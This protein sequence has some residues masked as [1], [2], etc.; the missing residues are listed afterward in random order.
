MYIRLTSWL[1]TVLIVWAPGK[2]AAQAPVAVSVATD[3]TPA[4][5]NSFLPAMSATGRF[6]A[7]TSFA[8]NLVPGDTNGV[9]D[10]FLR[11]RDTDVDGVFDEAGAV[12]T[13]RVSQRGGVE[14]IGGSNEAAI[15]A[16]GHYVVFSSFA[17]NLF[18]AAQA[19]LPTTAIL[20][21]DRLT[22][23]IVL[24]SQTTNGQLLQG[25]RSVA[26]DLADDGDTVVFLH[27]GSLDAEKEQGHRGIIYRRDI[28]AGTLTEVSTLPLVDGADRIAF[29]ES[30]TISGDGRT[31]A[32]AAV[33]KARFVTASGPLY[34]TTGGNVHLLDT[35]TNGIRSSYAG[36]S[37]KLS[38]NGAF[39]AFIGDVGLSPLGI[40]VR[41]HLASG[42]RLSTGSIGLTWTPASVSPS[43]RFFAVGGEVADYHYGSYVF[44]PVGDRAAF[45]STDTTAAVTRPHLSGLDSTPV[46]VVNLT[47]F[48]DADGDGLNDHWEAVFG[49]GT[50]PDGGASGVNGAA[51]DPDNDGVS[52]ADELA[53]GSNPVGSQAL[54]LAEGAAGTFFTTRYA[55]ANPGTTQANVSLRLDL[56]GGGHVLRTMWVPGGS[57]VS[58][59]SRSLGLGTASFSAAVESSQPVVADRLMSWGDGAVPYGSHA[60]TASTAPGTSW[61]LAEGSTVLGFQLF[62]LLQ[63]PQATATTA[64]VRFLLPS[65]APIVRTYAL[66]ARSRTTIL[67]TTCPGWHRPTSPPRS[68][69]PSASPSSGR[70]IA[71]A[72]DRSSLWDT[73]RV[74]WPSHRRRGSLPK[75]PPGRSSTPICCWP[76]HRR[77]RLR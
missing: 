28:A 24:V 23:D 16:D 47:T 56:D 31:I 19:P 42:E 65:G 9:E 8:T 75:A 20:R 55:I 45:D 54:F 70:C 5:N 6:V 3:G 71:P 60:E 51:G 63:N 44:A 68:P 29:N 46:V 15:T 52:N 37:P 33:Q 67:V 41:I 64:T 18:S 32:Y 17:A 12:S 36:T 43:G 39:L 69:P 62:Y 4:N 73:M 11:D 25:A 74:R 2:A 72:A 53:R 38:R 1:V 59:D 27:G 35:A 21:W 57:R 49:L 14:G 50:F 77:N 13:V 10:V 40:L 34:Q 22:G 7:F 66:P 26:P 30:P 76:T 48:L 61:I 58:I